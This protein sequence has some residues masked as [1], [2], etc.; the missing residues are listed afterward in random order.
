MTLVQM[1]S[2]VSLTTF[3]FQIFVSS[4]IKALECLDEF[5]KILHRIAFS[6][7]TID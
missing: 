3:R 1:M 5:V 4:Y 6:K 7:D 2:F